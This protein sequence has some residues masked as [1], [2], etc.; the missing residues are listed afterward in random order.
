MIVENELVCYY[1]ICYESTYHFLFSEKKISKLIICILR[2]VMSILLT[3]FMFQVNILFA[4]KNSEGISYLPIL[5]TISSSQTVHDIPHY[6]LPN[7]FLF[8]D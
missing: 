3:V 4:C 8:V 2:F 7:A 1:E 6:Y 5:S